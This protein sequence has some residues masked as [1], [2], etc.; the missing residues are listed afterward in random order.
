MSKFDCVTGIVRENLLM[1][2][3]MRIQEVFDDMYRLDMVDTDVADSIGSIERLGI[4]RDWAREFEEK[5]YDTD[6]Y[7]EDYIG[8]S[9]KFATEKI[10]EKFRITEPL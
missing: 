8:I 7:V 5:Y 10:K 9:D 3:A 6:E 2:T 1:E 4:F